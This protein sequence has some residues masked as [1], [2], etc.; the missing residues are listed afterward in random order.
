MPPDQK[1]DRDVETEIGVKQATM[2]RA[3]ACSRVCGLLAARGRNEE[4]ERAFQHISA[5]FRIDPTKPSHNVFARKYCS[6]HAIKDLLFRA[7]SGPSN[8]TLIKLTIDGRP[9][10]RSGVKIVRRFG[11]SIGDGAE[12]RCL[13]I[14][15]D[16]QGTLVTAYPATDG[17][18]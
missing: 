12:L 13:V 16:A 2:L 4:W 15:A 9:T 10:G 7:A 5:H 17:D 3:N 1:F 8:V 6:R 11:E 18:L 14:I